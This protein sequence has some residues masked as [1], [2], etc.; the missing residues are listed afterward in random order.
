MVL[1]LIGLDHSAEAG[2]VQQFDIV[3]YT[4]CIHGETILESESERKVDISSCRD[5][6]L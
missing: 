4:P 5:Y 2:L 3:L 6:R 1:I